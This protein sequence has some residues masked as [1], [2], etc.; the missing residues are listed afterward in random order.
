VTAGIKYKRFVW[1]P[2]DSTA[3]NPAKIAGSSSTARSIPGPRACR[4][5][6]A[7]IGRRRCPWEDWRAPS[8]SPG[9]VIRS[10]ASIQYARP[11]QGSDWATSADLGPQSRHVFT[12]HNL[13]SYLLESV[14]PWRRKNFFTGRIELVDKDDLFAISP[15]WK[16]SSPAPPA[17][18]FASTPTRP[19]TRATSAFQKVETGIGANFTAY[20]V[21]DAIKPYYGNHPKG[22]PSRR[23]PHWRSFV[24]ETAWP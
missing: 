23:T 2:A 13:N 11:M 17:A 7:R 21:P 19:A 18:R 8:E 3:P 16:S 12:Q 6:P 4:T 24:P 9:D 10:T 5:F 1:K 14:A 20:S 15:I 22:W